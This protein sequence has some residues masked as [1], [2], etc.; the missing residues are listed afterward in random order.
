MWRNVWTFSTAGITA[1]N[2]PFNGC[3]VVPAKL[4][5]ATYPQTQWGRDVITNWQKGGETC[6]GRLRTAEGSGCLTMSW[7]QSKTCLRINTGRPALTERENP[8]GK[9]WRQK[10]T[11]PWDRQRMRVRPSAWTAPAT[12]AHSFPLAGTLS[13]R[14]TVMCS[15]FCSVTN[16]FGNM[17]G[18]MNEKLIMPKHIQIA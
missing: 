11:P 7:L 3:V 17:K 14:P 13:S 5:V 2:V 12:H 18:H 4:G 16:A 10:T 6:L 15:E 1:R 8:C 9:D